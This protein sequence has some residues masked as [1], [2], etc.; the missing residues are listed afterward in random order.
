MNNRTGKRIWYKGTDGKKHWKS[1]TNT[2]QTTENATLDRTIFSEFLRGACTDCLS[3]VH[4]VSTHTVE[5][6]I[7]NGLSYTTVTL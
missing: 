4:L 6:A 2:K 3:K 7:R 5:E 1:L